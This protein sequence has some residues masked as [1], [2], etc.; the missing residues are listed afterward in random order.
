M[1]ASLGKIDEP[2]GRG[3]GGHRGYQEPIVVVDL[4]HCRV[5]EGGDSAAGLIGSR[6]TSVLRDRQ[7]RVREGWRCRQIV[8]HLGDTYGGAA[9]IRTIGRD[10]PFDATL[11]V[12][13]MVAV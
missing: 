1:L 3:G 4:R 8:G 12:I 2:I 10:E 11:D 6:C 9:V 13:V 7:R 5:R